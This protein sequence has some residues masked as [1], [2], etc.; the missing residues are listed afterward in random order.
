LDRLVIIIG[1]EA[2][3][4][5]SGKGSALGIGANANMVPLVELAQRGAEEQEKLRREYKYKIAIMQSRIAR[6]ERDYLGGNGRRE[7]G[8][9]RWL[10]GQ[11]RVNFWRRIELVEK[12]SSFFFFFLSLFSL[13]PYLRSIPPPS[14][15]LIMQATNS[16]IFHP[17][18]KQ[19]N[20]L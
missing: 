20:D 15:T 14:F 7:K 1:V 17:F 12:V 19:L 6:L 9:N 18:Q 5:G 4:G 8:Q 10:E 11:E 3:G 2:L 13:V 16:C